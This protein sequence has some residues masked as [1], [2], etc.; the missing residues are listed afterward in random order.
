[1]RVDDYYKSVRGYHQIVEDE[2]QE[3]FVV[4]PHLL[5]RFFDTNGITVDVAGGSGINAAIL[6]LHAT[7]YVC[8]DISFVGLTIA[9]EKKRGMYVQTD[10]KTLALKSNVADTVLCSWSL[11]HMTA[12]ESVLEEMMRIVKPGGRILIWGPNWDNIFRKDFPQFA[13]KDIGY[14]RSVRW[15]IFFKMMKN[16]F[17]PFRYDPYINPDVAA[18]AEPD[19]YISG[20]TDA[21]HC[22]LCQE[23]FKLLRARGMRIIHI[24]DF[25]EMGKHLN[26]GMYIRSIRSILRIFLPLLRC[27]PFL[28]WFVLRF[29]IVVEKPEIV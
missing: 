21:V 20:D 26:N 4:P 11:E 10:V 9:E 8:A 1:M 25:S 7:G 27:V 17:R 2:H 14:I 6:G 23:T 24:S 22:V 19:R 5:L 16:E 29:P 13:H 15:Q 12:P 18:L 3:V 28:R